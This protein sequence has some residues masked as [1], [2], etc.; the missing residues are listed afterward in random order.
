MCR[1]QE[2]EN[3]THFAMIMQTL[4]KWLENNYYQGCA[5]IGAPDNMLQDQFF[6]RVASGPV[7]LYGGPHKND[8]IPSYFQ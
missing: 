1:H 7:D 3:R 4:W 2:G 8:P 6:G 5:D